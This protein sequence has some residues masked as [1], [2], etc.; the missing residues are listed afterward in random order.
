MTALRAA[1]EDYLAMRRSLGFKLTSQG[2]LLLGFIDY[3]DARGARHITTELAVE[4]ATHPPRGG[5]DEVWWSRRL[6]VVR[7][8]ARHLAALDPDT[9]IPPQDVLPFHYRRV[10]PHLYGPADI[11]ALMAAAGR[12]APPLRAAS[13][14]TFL[15]LLAVTGMRV[16]EACRLDDGDIDAH[17]GAVVVADSKFG[18]SRL[19]FLHPSSISAVQ[20]YQWRRDQWIPTRSTPALLVTTRGTRLKADNVQRTFAELLTAGG[21]A[22]PPGRRRPRLHDLRHGFAVRT[23]LEWYRDGDDVQARLPLLSTWLGHVDPKSTYY[24][25]QAVPDLMVLAAARLEHLDRD[26]RS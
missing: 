11:A 12:L 19:V 24:Y 16:S 13:W 20:R 15:G 7:I 5:S 18:K 26:E 9:Q 25:L 21:I 14:Q 17:T 8:F 6:M 1:A 2:P 22:S 4:W 23:L 3:C 10:A